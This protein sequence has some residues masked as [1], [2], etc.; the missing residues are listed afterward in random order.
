MSDPPDQ[1]ARAPADAE[2]VARFVAESAAAVAQLDAHTM[3]L[4]WWGQE[5]AR[6]LTAGGR[7]LAC[8]NGG[9]AAQAQHLTA[10]LVGR[11]RDER[12]PLSAIALHADTSSL[13]ALGNDYGFAEV[14]ARQVLAHGREGDALVVLSTSGRSPNLLAAVT[15]AQRIGMHVV[16]MTGRAPNPLASAAGD[17]LCVDAVDTAVVQQVHLVAVHAICAV[18]DAAL[19]PT[20]APRASSRR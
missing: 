15:A 1:A 17:A 14:Y 19:S 4:A 8:G 20:P 9:S 5:L 3:R 6:I 10:E 11:F 18:V 7:V 2:E 16:A 12:R 13:T